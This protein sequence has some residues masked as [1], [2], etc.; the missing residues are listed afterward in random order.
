MIIYKNRF[1]PCTPN[2]LMVTP[3]PLDMMVDLGVRDKQRLITYNL[4]TM[5]KSWLCQTCLEDHTGEKPYSCDH[6]GKCFFPN[7][8]VVKS[9]SS[10]YL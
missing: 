10:S 2:P 7:R 6:C 9:G 1:L 4:C 8:R 3:L 5:R